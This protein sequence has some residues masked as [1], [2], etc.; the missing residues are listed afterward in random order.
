MIEVTITWAKEPR[1]TAVLPSVA[2]GGM[3]LVSSG[4]CEEPW[5]YWPNSLLGEVRV[6]REILCRETHS[7]RVGRFPSDC[8]PVVGRI[9]V[10]DRE[11]WQRPRG[12]AR[13]F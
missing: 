10:R 3:S 11:S 5:A 6:V 7:S 4:V 1:I 9:R 13:A 2:D 8:A 12:C